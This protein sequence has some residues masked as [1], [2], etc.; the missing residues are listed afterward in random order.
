[1]VIDGYWW[2]IVINGYQK[3]WFMMFKKGGIPGFMMFWNVLDTESHPGWYP[4]NDPVMGSVQDDPA[5]R[6]GRGP[7][8]AAVGFPRSGELSGDLQEDVPLCIDMHMM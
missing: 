2:L 8:A 6:F 7:E 3:F 1:M 4:M 5:G